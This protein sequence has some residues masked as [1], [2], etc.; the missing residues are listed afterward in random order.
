MSE[1]NA[2]KAGEAQGQ[3][4]KE[5]VEPKTSSG[6]DASI[7]K[8]LLT[9][10]E[11]TIKKEPAAEV[12][13][14][15]VPDAPAA[16]VS[17]QPGSASNT[18]SEPGQNT[19]EPA[20]GEQPNLAPEPA[21]P[22]VTKEFLP[23]GHPEV[24]QSETPMDLFRS[25]ALI[26]PG[27]ALSK[28]KLALSTAE[29]SQD[30]DANNLFAFLGQEAVLKYKKT[31]NC[32]AAMTVVDF[33]NNYDMLAQFLARQLKGRELAAIFCSAESEIKMS[34]VSLLKL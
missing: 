4:K 11:I 19:G 33:E 23:L 22:D 28:M 16:M 9:V 24:K 25:A 6:P 14:V 12:G 8:E 20:S 27:I 34:T 2:L 18:A 31:R 21:K 10:P 13:Q 7:K 17:Y 32:L 26:C 15:Q 3:I 30:M 5:L 1:L 29:K